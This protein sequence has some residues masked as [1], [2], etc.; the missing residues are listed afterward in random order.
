MGEEPIWVA[1][2]VNR[3][4]GKPA[5]EL[6]SVLHVQPANPDYPIPNSVSMEILVF[7]IA[8]LF[9]LWLKGRISVDR[10][11]ATQQVMEMVIT[12]K[13]GVG[14]RDLIND[15]IHHGEKY[16]PLIG[17]IG[18]FV[19]FSN[20]INVIPTLEAPTATVTVPLGCAMIVFVYYHLAGIFKQGPLGHAKHFLGPVLPMAPLMLPIEIFSHSFRLLSLTVRL[21]VNM[22]VSELLYTVFLGLMLGVYVYLGKL[23]VL[24]QASAVFPIFIPLIFIVLHIFVAILQAFV[25]TILPII[26]VSEAVAEHH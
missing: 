8:V 7:I 15:N 20:L 18:I 9:F 5:G 4:L 16:L 11:G 17:S 1:V 25:F 19:L 6:L 2:V 13:M 3:I 26:Y 22:L 21:W 14:I 24:G 23:S 12:N 10:P